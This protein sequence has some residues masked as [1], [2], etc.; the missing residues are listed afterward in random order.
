MLFRSGPE[1]LEV[2]RSQLGMTRDIIYRLAPYPMSFL[3][4][5]ALLKKILIHRLGTDQEY[6]VLNRSLPGNV[7]SEMGLEI[8]D[9]A[10]LLRGTPEVVS[11][12]EHAED[13]TF[14]DGLAPLPGGRKFQSAFEAFIAKYGVRCPGEI[15]ITRPRW[16]EAPTMLV[17]AILGH[18]RSVKPGEHRQKFRQGEQDASDALDRIMNLLKNNRFKAKRAKRLIEVFRHLGALREH[19][20][21]F[22]IQ[23]L[24]ECKQAIMAEAQDLVNKKVLRYPE[25][26]YFLTLDE[27]ILLTKGEFAGDVS[28]LIAERESK[29]EWFKTLKPP[30][31]MTSEGEMIT[32]AP[33][34]GHFPEGALVGSPISAGVAEGKARIVLSPEEASLHEGEILVAPFTDPGWTP[35]FQSATAVVTEIGGLMTHGAVVAREY[36]IPAVVGIDNA[37]SKIHDGQWI[38]VDGTQGFVEILSHEEISEIQH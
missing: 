10:D 34:A 26:A 28:Q 6:Y 30:R 19:H 3:I 14:Y 5:S 38:R 8:G 2:V 18:L 31:V 9:L 11:Y 21:F 13:D 27:L 17:P 35:L 22:L 1:R 15:D 32:G 16:R 24:G 29:Q 23:I 4:A 25:E 7:T 20:K 36:G 33:K 37:T 12:L